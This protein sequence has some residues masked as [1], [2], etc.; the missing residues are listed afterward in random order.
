MFL[1]Q[2]ISFIL[3]Y[4]FQLHG[5]ANHVGPA[6]NVTDLDQDQDGDGL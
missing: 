6:L 5:T 4:V 1:Q 3:F 2:N